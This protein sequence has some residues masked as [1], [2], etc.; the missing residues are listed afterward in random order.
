MAGTSY[1]LDLL[2]CDGQLCALPCL[3]PVHDSTMV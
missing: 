1:L 3:L 2:T